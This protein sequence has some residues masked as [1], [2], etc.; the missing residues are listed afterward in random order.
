MLKIKNEKLKNIFMYSG[1][2]YFAQFFKGI[3][4]IFS[5]NVLGPFLTGQFAY[6][7]LIYTYMLYGH[8]GIRFAIDKN[9]PYIYNNCS[10]QEI[11]NYE[12]K[13]ITSIFLLET[14]FAICGIIFFKIYYDKNPLI[15]NYLIYITFISSIFFSLNEIYKVIYRAEEKIKNISQYSLYYYIILS[16][17]QIISVYFYRLEGLVYGI[18]IT[19]FLF[20]LVYFYIINKENLVIE[21]DLKFILSMIKEGFPLFINGLAV[22]TLLNI[23]RWF[24][25]KYFEVEKLGYYS[26]ATMFFSMLLILPN[27]ISEVLF[28]GLLKNIQVIS[29]E[30][31]VDDLFKNI[32]ILTKVFYIIISIGILLI[33]MFIKIFMPQYILSIKIIQ[34]LIASIFSFAISTL[35]SYTLLGYNKSKTILNIS[36]F[37]LI[38]ATT[39]NII[40]LNIL[41]KDLIYIALASFITYIIYASMYL[42]SIYKICTPTENKFLKNIITNAV[43]LI[44]ILIVSIVKVNFGIY[45]LIFSFLIFDSISFL[46]VYFINN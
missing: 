45:I 20:Y 10:S 24:I 43:K 14:F 32:S 19:N 8:L 18:L 36:T 1:S 33:P 25:I 44:I 7:N 42:Y 3:A 23:D 4:S 21:F 31:Y 46:K 9:L 26:V 38:I 16:V 34:I 37:S 15:P 2:V 12:N 30:K 27:T 29:K 11:K 5:K 17:V 39:L 22:F 41:G 13:S 40:F 6:L 28:P 35:T